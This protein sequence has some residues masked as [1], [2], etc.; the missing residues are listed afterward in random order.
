[1]KIIDFDE[2]HIKEAE[3]LALENYAEE[4]CFVPALPEITAIP[5]L[6]C[7]AA[8][9]LG[10]AA[11]E[12][13]RLIGYLCCPEPWE[14]A[15]DTA[16]SGV[17]SPLHANGAAKK[18]RS[19][20]YRRMYQAAARK[21]IDRSAAYHAICLY[22]HAEEALRGLFFYGFGMRC[23]DAVRSAELIGAAPPNGI[24]F[25]ELEASELPVVRPLRKR[26]SD[27]MGES[28][29]FMLSSPE[30]FECWLERRECSGTRLFAAFDGSKAIAFLEL[31]G[32]GEN[33]ASQSPDMPNICG[34]YCLP[35]Y[36][37]KDVYAALLDYVVSALRDEGFVRIGVDFES[38]NPTAS[39]FW[40]K[41]FSAYTASVTR[42]ID[43]CALPR[44]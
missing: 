18:N 43:D 37:G 13:D 32:E 9:G 15:F 38:I 36:R 25:R 40:L 34:A 8:N 33:F 29:C 3:R 41:H 22:A 17:F 21:W 11:L 10:V 16:A 23:I 5:P 7:F 12:D 19:M 6:D 27:H 44:G 2:S 31:G 24:V 20:I 4:R 14:N 26:L 30:E 28:P 39:G 42:R 35:E 1:M